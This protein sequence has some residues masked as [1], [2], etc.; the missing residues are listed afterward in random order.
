MII[1]S[2]GISV[3]SFPIPYTGNWYGFT[4][5]HMILHGFVQIGYLTACV[6]VFEMLGPSKAGFITRVEMS[7]FVISLKTTPKRYLALMTSIIFS[8]G[9]G[10]V[11]LWESVRNFY[12]LHFGPNLHLRT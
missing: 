1:S 9:Y 4:V 7:L 3:F 5:L 12:S 6:Y 10:S 8:L 11:S 2:I